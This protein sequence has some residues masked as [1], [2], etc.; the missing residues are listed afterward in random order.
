MKALQELKKYLA[1]A[2]EEKK[3][4]ILKSELP[5][6]KEHFEKVDKDIKALEIIKAKQVNVKNLT[7]FCI[8]ND[9]SYEDYVDNFNYYDDDT[10]FDLGA[11]LLTEEEYGLLKE[12]LL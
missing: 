7:W 1:K 2:V 6:L 10:Y 11:T 8:D 3:I 5:N 9:N 12:V 4:L